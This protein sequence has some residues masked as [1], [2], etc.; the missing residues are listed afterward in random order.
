MT[1]HLIDD[2]APAR[3][4][5]LLAAAELMDQAG[6]GDVS[7]RAICELAGVQAPTLYHHFG[8]KDGLLDAVVSHGFRQF[9]QDQQVATSDEDPIDVIRRGWDIHVRFG[10]QNPRFYAHIYG[11]VEAGKRCQVVADM[12]EMLLRALEPAARQGRISV[13]PAEAAAA[14]LAASSGVTLR[15]ITSSTDRVDWQ[16]SNRVRDAMLESISGTGKNRRGP[17][18]ETSVAAAAITL[19]SLLDDSPTALT[20]AETT[21]LRQWLGRLTAV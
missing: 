9:L 14:I 19:A 10:V 1:K 15:L 13:S 12:E 4:R 21:L 8:S 20:G 18:K 17:N 5:L 7:T 6:G 16:L 3:D 11:R 2:D